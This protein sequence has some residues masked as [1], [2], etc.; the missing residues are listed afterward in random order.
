MLEFNVRFG[1][2]ETQAVLPLLGGDLAGLF[3][4]AA[5]GRKLPEPTVLSGASAVVIVASEGY[6]GEYRKGAVIEGLDAVGD[7]MVFHAGTTLSGRN[8]VTS[9]GRVLGVTA[10]GEDL[11]KA[12]EK[13][14]LAVESI[15]FD[16]MNF[17]RDI[18]RAQ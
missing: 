9:G 7:A 11:G 4:A 10:L 6:P 16:G 18:G 14:Y 8:I 5:L 3:A 12:L 15:H 1:D 17:R 2:P 13:A